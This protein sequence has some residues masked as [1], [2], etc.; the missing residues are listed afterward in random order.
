M[1]KDTVAALNA[2][3]LT[4]TSNMKMESAIGEIER[5]PV[6]GII[7]EGVSKFWHTLFVR[8]GLLVVFYIVCCKTYE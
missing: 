6:I 3:K 8:Y 2:E 1:V 7:R 4:T 5:M